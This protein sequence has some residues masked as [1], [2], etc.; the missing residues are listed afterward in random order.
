MKTAFI[1]C[2]QSS[3][4]VPSSPFGRDNQNEKLLLTDVLIAYL[5]PNEVSL[6]SSFALVGVEFMKVV[7]RKKSAC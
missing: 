2:P 7:V 3:L 5:V 4:A 1:G 6:E